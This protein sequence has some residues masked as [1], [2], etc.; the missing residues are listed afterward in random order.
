VSRI[1]LAPVTVSP[2][3]PLTPT[4]LKYLLSLDLLARATA[5]FAEVTVLYRHATYAGSRQVAGF[6]EYLDRCHPQADSAELSEEQIGELYGAYHR[7]E[8][9]EFAA[10][11]ATVRRAEAGWVHPVSARLLDLWE[12]HYELLGL[13]DPKLGRS[14]PAPGSAAKTLELL[15]LLVE[16]DLCIDARELD[17]PVYLDA[18]AAGLPLRPV[19]GPDGQANYLLYLLRELLPLLAGHDLV[20]LAHDTELRSDYRIVAHVLSTLGTEADRFEVPRVPI[21]GVVQSTRRGGWQGYT[22]GALAGGPIAE[23][24][25]AAFQLG[26][27]L[28]LVAGLGG[29]APQSFSTAHL[30][31]WVRR[32]DRLLTEH[33]RPQHV[34]AA[35]LGNAADYLAARAGRKRYADPYQVATALL[36]TDPSVPV[37]GLLGVALG[38]GPV[39]GRRAMAMRGGGTDD[40][41]R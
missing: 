10:V 8:R 5:T 23:F 33:G 16:H 19:L 4:H 7:T 27:R 15:E 31:R 41:G 35:E 26:L 14:G 6:W 22:L 29:T 13:A 1:L 24:G 21:D 30:R 12:Q 9:Q 40:N 37:A 11:E 18:T 36:S 3:K 39:G 32:A 34:G 28:Y 25:L 20:L 38:R 17:A 2:T